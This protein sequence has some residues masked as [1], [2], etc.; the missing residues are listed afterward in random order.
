MEVVNIG[1]INQ[2]ERHFGLTEA[3]AKF[4]EEAASVCLDRHHDS[5]RDFQITQQNETMEARAEWGAPDERTK[6]AWGNRDDATEAGAY[7]LALAAVELTKGLV[8]VR[9]AETLTGSDYYLGLPG[10]APS[11]MRALLRLEFSGWMR[12]GKSEQNSAW[13][14]RFAK[15][16]MEEVSFPP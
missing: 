14:K 5:P 2:H 16:P 1:L 9:R 4:F 12:A 8:A 13:T 7:C 11:D 10:E 15:P 3:V 6:G